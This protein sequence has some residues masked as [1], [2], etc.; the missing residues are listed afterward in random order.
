VNRFTLPVLLLGAFA[1]SSAPTQPPDPSSFPAE[2]YASL[3]ANA[4]KVHIDLRTSPQPPAVGNDDVQL[5]ITDPSGSPLDGLTVAVKPWMPAHGHGTSE[6]TVTAQGGGKYL[7][8][9]V[10]LYMSGVWQLQI[11]VSGPVSDYAAPELELP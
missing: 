4:G 10:Y 9:D 2:P 5:T 8:T 7:V 6:T 3:T 1:C 11:T